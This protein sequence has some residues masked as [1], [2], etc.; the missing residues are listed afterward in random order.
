MGIQPFQILATWNVVCWIFKTRISDSEYVNAKKLKLKTGYL[1]F[2]SWIRGGV[3]CWNSMYKYL[4][5]KILWV[6]KFKIGWNRFTCTIQPS[7]IRNNNGL[8]SQKTCVRLSKLERCQ[9]AERKSWHRWEKCCQRARNK[10]SVH[11][12]RHL[13]CCSAH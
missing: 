11:F 6:L 7:N 5:L 9:A 3:R 2:K 4:V 12:Q 1:K 13:L 10:R 8:D